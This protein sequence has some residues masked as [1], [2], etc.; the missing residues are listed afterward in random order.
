[1]QLNILNYYED[2][3]PKVLR[4]LT[5]LYLKKYNLKCI[6]YTDDHSKQIKLIKKADILFL[7]PG[8]FLSDELIS[9]ARNVKLIQIWSS[10]YDKLNLKAI[11]KYKIPLA[12]NYSVNSFSVAEHTVMLM[13]N[14][15]RKFPHFSKITNECKW[16]GNSHGTDCFN[17]KN[18]KVGIIGLGNV[19]K[20]VAK[21]CKS[22]GSQ[23]F[24]TDI[25]IKKYL[26]YKSVRL[27]KIFQLCDI[28]TIHL[29]YN[30]NTKKIINKDLLNLMHKNSFLIN[31]SRAGLIDNKHLN[32][33]LKNKKIAGVGIDVFEREPTKTGDHFIKIDNACLTPHTAGSTID[34]YKDVLKVC[35][36][37]FE[38]IKK[39]Q[40]VKLVK[41]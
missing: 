15:L 38:K 32:K 9:N 22:F 26:D 30:K 18:K 13:L 37:N 39:K 35:L 34:T 19:G 21:I 2:R 16:E 11:K 7:T 8:R 31:V 17:L 33:L 23:I 1:M 29:H 4:D 3:I 36:E 41:I 12:N 6:K 5:K 14:C 28:V 25:N 10:G 20:K 27:K 24:F 40:K